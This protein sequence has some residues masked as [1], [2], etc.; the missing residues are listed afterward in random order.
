MDEKLCSLSYDSDGL[1]ADYSNVDFDMEECE[2]YNNIKLVDNEISE[3]MK[4]MGATEDFVLISYADIK[5]LRV[6]N[7][8]TE[9]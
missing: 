9:L 7:L 5:N 2:M 1:K 8:R 4:P 6:D 3:A